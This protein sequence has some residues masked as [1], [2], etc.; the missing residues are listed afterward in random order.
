[1]VENA[2]KIEFAEALFDNESE[3]PGEL[4]FRKGDI[5]KIVDKKLNSS[6]DGWWVC[7]NNRGSRGIVPAN[8]LKVVDKT[9]WSSSF[10]SI[11]PPYKTHNSD[12]VS[13]GDM[14]ENFYSIPKKNSVTVRN[15]PITIEKQNR[16]GQSS[17][18]FS[19][20]PPSNNESIMKHA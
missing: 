14:N 12:D 7:S 8:R 15:V 5:L 9:H 4:E 13:V 6:V 20:L 3:W 10:V 17:P 16:G 1:M 18:S 2:D 11:D 19:T